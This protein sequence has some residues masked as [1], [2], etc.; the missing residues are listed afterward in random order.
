MATRFLELHGDRWSADDPAIV[1]GLAELN[2]QTTIVIGH[3][4]GG[5]PEEKAASHDGKAYSEGY[6]KSLRLMRLA[7]KFRIPVVT[8][9]DCP[10]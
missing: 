1:G 4:R 8:L 3:D 2:G 10:L 7:S 5:T 6:R 9:V